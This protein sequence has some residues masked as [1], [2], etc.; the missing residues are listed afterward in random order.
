MSEGESQ[1]TDSGVAVL[2]SILAAAVKMRK[3]GRSHRG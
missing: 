1:S 2:L 3:K